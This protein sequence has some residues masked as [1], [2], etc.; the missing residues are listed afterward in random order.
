MTGATTP[1]F[2]QARAAEI[3]SGRTNSVAFQA[4]NAAGNLIVVSVFWDNTSSV[5]VADSRGNTYASGG[6]RRTWGS[7]RSAQVF[8]ARNVAA[9]TNTVTATFS[10]AIRVSAT[11]HVHEYSGV[12]RAAAADAT[13]GGV[14]SGTALSSGTATTTSAGD[15]LFATGA[16]TGTVTQPGAGW[17]ARSTASG[18]L[19]ADRLAVAAGPYSA[20]ATA[21]SGSWV[22]QLVAFKPDASTADTTPPTVAVTAPAPA[23]P[24]RA[25]SR[26]PPPPRTT[27]P[28][29]VSASSSMARPW[30]PRTPR[31]RTR[32]PGPPRRAPTARTA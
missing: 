10:K 3:T 19:T 23:R 27:W 4:P 21:T 31:R 6:A 26:S 15:L 12:D 14:G 2:V 7:T 24:C 20:T 5:S 30:V 17:T 22:M 25:T 18:D 8:Y 28:W 16:S 13:A 1:S 9:G 11:V 32:C 29:P